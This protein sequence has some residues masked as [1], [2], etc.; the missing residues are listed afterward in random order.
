MRTITLKSYGKLILLSI[1]GNDSAVKAIYGT[2]FDNGRHSAGD[3]Y[4]NDETQWYGRTSLCRN[5]RAAYK[6]TSTKLRSGVTHQLI[7]DDRFLRVSEKDRDSADEGTRY[8]LVKPGEI[9]ADLVYQAVLKNLPTPTLPEWSHAIY[10]ELLAL[11]EDFSSL[12]KG[13]IEE[14]DTYPEEIKVISVQVSEEA[15]DAVVSDLVKRGVI[16]WE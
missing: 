9:T 4:V 5:P 2:L 3:I 16:G 6:I 15:L 7:Y 14:I 11:S 13:R 10:E 8:V 1:I 12:T